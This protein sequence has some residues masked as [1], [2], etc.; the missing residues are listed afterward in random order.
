[1]RAFLPV[2]QPFK[3]LYANRT[4]FRKYIENNRGC[5]EAD[6]HYTSENPAGD[7]DKGTRQNMWKFG[8]Y[9]GSIMTP[10]GFTATKQLALRSTCRLQK[11]WQR[12]RSTFT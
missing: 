9:Q 12:Y 5:S 8:K 3:W 2:D 6:A 4:E 10:L 1:M 11:I 7:K